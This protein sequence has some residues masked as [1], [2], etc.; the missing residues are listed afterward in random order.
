MKWLLSASSSSRFLSVEHRWPAAGLYDSGGLRRGACRAL[1]TVGSPPRT[2]QHSGDFAGVLCAVLASSPWLTASSGRD[3][4]L[5]QAGSALQHTLLPKMSEMAHLCVCATLR[6]E[7]TILPRRQCAGLHRCTDVPSLTFLGEL[8]RLWVCLRW[9]QHG[10]SVG[11]VPKS[12]AKS[13]AGNSPPVEPAR[14]DAQP[15]RPPACC[16]PLAGRRRPPT[17]F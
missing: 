2:T 1:R 13:C 12:P 16:C 11:R 9:P 8:L 5:R 10:A 14:H 7:L 15:A 3:F 17:A 6:A 4:G